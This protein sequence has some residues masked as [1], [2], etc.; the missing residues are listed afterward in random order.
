[1][2]GAPPE[3]RAAPQAQGATMSPPAGPASPAPAFDAAAPAGTKGAQDLPFSAAAERNKA[4]I[5]AVL[6]AVLPARA[7]VVEVA[8]GTGQHAAHFAAAQPGWTWQPSDVHP[9]TFDAVAA[10]CAA[11]ANVRRAIALDVLAPPAAGVADGA[12]DAV[13][14]ANLIHIAPWE[15]C[16]ALLRLAARVLTPRGAL[17]VYG[18]FVEAGVPT[19]EGN[20][21]FD[22]D[23]RERNPRWGLRSVE[24]VDAEASR[25]GLRRVERHAMP[26]NNLTLVFRRAPA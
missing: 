19:A 10:R 18:P 2:G 4:P 17:V 9:R 11:L 3:R 16:G 7:R 23:L 14:C 22:A 1:M 15:A 12:F 8:S 24:D 21:A 20:L 5:L 25:A 6:A 26:A 13:Y